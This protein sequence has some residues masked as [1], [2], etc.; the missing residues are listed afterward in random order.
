MSNISKDIQQRVAASISEQNAIIRE[1]IDVIHGLWVA[2]VGQL[3]TCQLGPGG[4]GKSMLVRDLTSHIEG[5][6]YF[7][8]A[9]DETTDPGQ[10]FGPPD[11]KAMVEQGKT[12]RVTTGMLPEAT[13]AFVDEIF[14][15][16]SPTLHSL[17]PVMNERIF[18]N[19]G[20][21]TDAPLRSLHSGTNKLNADADLAAFFDRLHLRFTVDY[22]RSRANRADMVAMAVSRM[23]IA[24][25]GTVTSVGTGITKVTLD[26][27]DIA[28]KE[29]L[30]LDVPDVV[31]DTFL[32]LREELE[33]NGIRV[34]DRRMNEG[35]V[36]VL[37]NAWVRGHETVT[38]GDLDVLAHAWWI[39]QDQ[40]AQARSIVLSITNPGEK[41]ALDLL[42]DLDKIKK[43]LDDA[44]KSGLD[45]THKRRLAVEA[46]RNTDK[47]L[48]EAS[49]V[50][51]KAQAA[52]TDTSRLTEVV[53]RSKQFKIHIGV[54][55]FGVKPA[56]IELASTA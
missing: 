2:R 48:A 41:K 45:E 56:D 29:A 34:S 12:R 42:D 25:R 8:T 52:G 55:Y 38:V 46:V 28:H 32:D 44:N 31:L 4:T 20:V 13:D 40:Q 30:A 39:L 24:G 27:L 19:N 9:L 51:T 18:H 47:L 10:V 16:N 26:E 37:A 23:A 50:L 1:R 6:K 17:M 5:A 3:H 53:D 22:V 7:E 43:E 35:M 21:P 15:G 14:N 49:E 33:G 36:A 54:E 11:I